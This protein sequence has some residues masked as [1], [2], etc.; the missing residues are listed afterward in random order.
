M[1]KHSKHANL[2]RANGGDFHRIEIGIL[3]APC[4]TIQQLS[5]QVAEALKEEYQLAYVDAEHGAGES[6]G[7]A[8]AA[9]STDKISFQ[10]Y[11]LSGWDSA[12]SRLALSGL[13]AAIVNGNHFKASAQVVIVNSGKRESLQR[14]LKRIINP[15]LVLLDEGMEAPFDFLTEHLGDAVDLPILKMEQQER[16]VEVLK[17]HI[18]SFAA[19]LHGLVLAGGKSQRMGT[20]KGAIVYHEKPQSDHLADL[21]EGFCEEIYFSV[22][23][24]QVL[25][26]DRH[27][28]QDSFLGLGP[29]GAILTAFRQNPEAAYLVLPCDVPLVDKA[30]LEELVNARNEAKVATCFYNPETDFP[31]PLI[32]IWEP[33]SYALM[34]QWLSRGYACPRKVLINADVQMIKTEQSAKLMNANTVEERDAVM[35][36]IKKSKR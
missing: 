2:Q 32:S 8:F 34:L 6:L 25:D 22:A 7:G 3:G 10:R 23:P 35:Q 24:G 27:Q 9:Y 36:L 16:I 26:S 19:P 28:L 13:S 11:D 14:K 12:T 33:K 21:L 17:A 29:M 20:D 1:K 4:G 30:L 5:T 18:Q 31:E 15:I